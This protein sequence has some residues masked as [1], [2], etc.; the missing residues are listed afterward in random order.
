MPTSQRT[1][2]EQIYSYL[3][4]SYSVFHSYRRSLIPNHALVR[5]EGECLVCPAALAVGHKLHPKISHQPIGDVG[6]R[7]LRCRRDRPRA[8]LGRSHGNEYHA[9]FSARSALAAGRRRISEAHRSFSHDRSASPH[10]SRVGH[11]RFLL[12]SFPPPRSPASSHS[13]GSQFWLGTESRRGCAHRSST[14][15][16]AERIRARYCGSLCE[17]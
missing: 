11:F 10:P 12:G 5:A 9:C 16:A 2:R 17:R 15:S 1:T 6:G 14:I 4:S 8:N 3:E 13:R 7:H